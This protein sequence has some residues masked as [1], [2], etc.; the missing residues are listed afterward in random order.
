M[1][2]ST[3]VSGSRRF[4]DVVVLEFESFSTWLDSTAP[5]LSFEDRVSSFASAEVVALLVFFFFRPPVGLDK[6][7]VDIRGFGG[8]DTGA[9]HM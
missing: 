8:V 2:G 5:D 1:D 9:C 3:T 4:F 6:S 7:E